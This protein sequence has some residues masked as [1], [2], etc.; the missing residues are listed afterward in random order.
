MHDRYIYTIFFFLWEDRKRKGSKREEWKTQQNAFF[1]CLEMKKKKSCEVH[2]FFL[3]FKS[4]RK[5]ERGVLL[6]LKL[7]RQNYH[8]FYMPSLV[9][10]Q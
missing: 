2:A 5:G 1:H 4:G 6:N 3:L 8:Y 7:K 10:S 9:S